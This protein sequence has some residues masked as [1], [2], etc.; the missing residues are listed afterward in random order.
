MSKRITI[1]ST[2]TA[3]IEETWVYEVPDNWEPG[4]D[5]ANAL[6]VLEGDSDA[7]RFVSCEDRVT[8]GERD[9]EITTVEEWK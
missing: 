2:G 3:Q 8:G 4:D 6:D 1:V 7:V 9:R 5:N